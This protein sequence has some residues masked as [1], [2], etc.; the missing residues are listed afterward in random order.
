[1]LHMLKVMALLHKETKDHM[2]KVVKQQ[3]QE[4]L[5]IVRAKEL[6]RIVHIAMLK[7]TVL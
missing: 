2:P 7:D 6:K 1:M 4:T 3:L 5:H